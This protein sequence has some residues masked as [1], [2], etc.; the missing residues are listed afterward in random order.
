MAIVISNH[1]T[2]PIPV[3]YVKSTQ[4][5]SIKTAISLDSEDIETAIT[6]AYETAREEENK[7][8]EAQ[9]KVDILKG[10]LK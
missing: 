3:V 9:I 5:S 8:R 6:E 1:I 10:K 4:F 7:L 2:D